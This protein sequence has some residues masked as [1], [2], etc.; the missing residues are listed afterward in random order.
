MFLDG[1]SDRIQTPERSEYIFSNLN[2][3]FCILK[4]QKMSKF[5]TRYLILYEN[6]ILKY[7][8][9]IHTMPEGQLCNRISATEYVAH[10]C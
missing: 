10:C 7:P 8:N 5:H 9:L 4:I 3:F 1:R 6:L 2:E